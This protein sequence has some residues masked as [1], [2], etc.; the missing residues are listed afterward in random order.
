MPYFKQNKILERLRLIIKIVSLPSAVNTAVIH[1]DVI[2]I[3]ISLLFLNYS[4]YVLK[5]SFYVFGFLFSFSVWCI[6]RVCIVFV[7]LLYCTVTV[8]YCYCMVLLLYCTVNVLYCYCIVLLLYGTIT[9][10]YC[11]CIVLLLYCTVTVLF[12]LWSCIFPLFVKVYWP[13]P[14]GGNP[15]AVNKY[16]IRYL[17]QYSVFLID[18]LLIY[19]RIVS[20][21]GLPVL[22]VH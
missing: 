17:Y 21:H 3:S 1:C 14:P 19:W 2:I 15:I 4:T 5:H 13:L 16:H 12:P 22:S 20:Q 10:L 11:Y 18:V 8:L 9:V 6:V 7:L